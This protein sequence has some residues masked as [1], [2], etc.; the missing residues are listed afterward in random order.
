MA[1]VPPF[2]ATLASF[3]V[4]LPPKAAELST[5]RTINAGAALSLSVAQVFISPP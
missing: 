2:T 1:V 4:L 5:N 3:V